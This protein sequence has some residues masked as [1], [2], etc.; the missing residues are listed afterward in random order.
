MVFRYW[1]GSL[2]IVLGLGA[3]LDQMYFFNFGHWLSMLWPLAV[4][5]LGVLY[6]LTRETTTFGSILVTVFGTVMLL[7][8]LGLANANIL[9]LLW[10]TLLILAG[11]YFIFWMGR[12]PGSAINSSD[13]IQLFAVFSGPEVRLTTANF[14]GGNV[15]ALFGG[16]NIDLR[17]SKLPPEGALVELTAAFGGITLFVPEEWKLEM[18]GLPL[19]GGW[20]NKSALHSIAPEAP[21]LR[22]RCLAFCGGI[23]VKNKE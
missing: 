1:I 6:L 16:A 4:I 10:P 13:F 12:R 11:V 3:L 5:L 7:F 15:T 20:S 19:F 18:T 22:L 17:E 8:T 21:T 14:K 9:D 23:D 2:L